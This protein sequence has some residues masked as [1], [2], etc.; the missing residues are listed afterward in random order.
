MTE[1]IINNFMLLFQP[2]FWPDDDDV[3]CWNAIPNP[4]NYYIYH[5]QSLCGRDSA[6]VF[7]NGGHDVVNYVN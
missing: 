5:K 7:P 2:S 1:Y 6:T 3:G 4:V